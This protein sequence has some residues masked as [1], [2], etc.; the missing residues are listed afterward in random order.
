[1]KKEWK[2]GDTFSGYSVN[3]SYAQ[4]SGNTF[5]ENC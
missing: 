5:E 1:M 4:T 2:G 3:N